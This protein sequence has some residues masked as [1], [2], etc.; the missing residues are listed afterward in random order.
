MQQKRGRFCLVEE[1]SLVDTSIYFKMIDR[2]FSFKY[3]TESE[4]GSHAKDIA[5]EYPDL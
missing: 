3:N 4:I 5:R 2:H 1:T